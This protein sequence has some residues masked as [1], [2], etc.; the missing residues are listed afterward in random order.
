MTDNSPRRFSPTEASPMIVATDGREQ[1]DAAVRAG[2]LLAGTSDAWR[3]LTVVSPFPAIATEL[4]LQLAATA[5][6]AHRE[7][8]V[9][10]VRQ[11]VRRILGER[12]VRVEA[13]DG[14]P[15]DVIARAATTLNA[16]LIVA[17]LGRHKIIDR[18]LGDETAL[19]LVR[20]AT[21]P[22]LAVAA[23]FVTPKTI[24][25]GIDFSENSLHAAQL[26]LR[27]ADYGATVFLMN[28]APR[29]LLLDTVV[30][31]P[32][33]Y[34]EHAMERMSEL[35]SRLD[36]P[37][38]VHL[39]PVVQHGD[40]GSRILEYAGSAHAAMI[41]IGTRGLGFMARM[42]VGSVATKVIRGSS[43]AVLTLPA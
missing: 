18:V 14:R 30:G 43:I 1:S 6:D 23:E 29:D 11:Q 16:S 35:R 15:A 27:F 4:D 8:H 10:S 36:A 40:A 33:A 21:T 9:R 32:A 7:A 38:G 26:A 39:Q 25:V 20:A 34:D 5:V 41:A 12:P 13:L 24:V 42:L 22:V 3:V 2:A 28:V 31:G 17:G 19:Q 37:A